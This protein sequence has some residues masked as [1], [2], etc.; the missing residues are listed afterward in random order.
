MNN[1][2]NFEIDCNRKINSKLLKRLR[3]YTKENVFELMK[4]MKTTNL[5]QIIYHAKN[6][7][8]ERKK[9]GFCQA[10]G[11]NNKTV[12]L[13]LKKG[14]RKY[15][16]RECFF[17]QPRKISERA[18]KRMLARKKRREYMREYFRKRTFK[19]YGLE[20][21][22][23]NKKIL[24]KKIIEYKEKRRKEEML[25]KY[26]VLYPYQIEEVFKKADEKRKRTLR[27][28]YGYSYTFSVPSIKEKAKKTFQRKYGA[29]NFL[30]SEKNKKRLEKLKKQNKEKN[31]KIQNS[32]AA[33]DKNTTNVENVNKN[34][35]MKT[36]FET[37]IKRKKLPPLIEK[38]IFNN[39]W[40]K[41]LVDKESN[42]KRTRPSVA[43]KLQDKEYVDYLIYQELL[44]P[45]EMCE[46]LGID[47]IYLRRCLKMHGYSLKKIKF[48]VQKEKEKLEDEFST[49]I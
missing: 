27:M 12:F 11:C 3:K 37:M 10:E 25:K 26:G 17:K 22:P 15:C 41:Y 8:M 30:A 20:Y 7:D 29:P 48:I 42:V 32:K 18:K 24:K 34:K 1:E 6:Q 9:F 16:S 21:L 28:K 13:S 36:S 4:K 40:T 39:E 2:E 43:S 35:K 49:Q 5:A 47:K 19:R 14:Y 23:E 31:N 38:H 44:T 46:K 33:N 45:E